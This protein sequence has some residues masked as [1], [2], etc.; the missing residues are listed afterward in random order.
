MDSVKLFVTSH[1]QCQGVKDVELSTKTQTS[2]PLDSFS[3]KAILKVRKNG[4]GSSSNI[5]ASDGA[6]VSSTPKSVITHSWD[7]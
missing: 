6:S 3:T 2:L 4:L 5:S 1:L 7:I